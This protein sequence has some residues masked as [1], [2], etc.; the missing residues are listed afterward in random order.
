MARDVLALRAGSLILA[1]IVAGCASPS[2]SPVRS[3]GAGEIT[4]PTFSQDLCA[5]GGFIQELRLRGD[6]AD[7][8]VVWLEN[9]AGE[10]TD[11]AW[12]PGS[13]ARFAPDLEILDPAGQVIAR[14]GA[15]ATGGCGTGAADV[16][17]VDFTTPAP[18]VT[19]PPMTAEP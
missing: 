5:G 12:L 2:P 6:S 18:D 4:V 19:E 14:E 3:L 17:Y 15:I 16:W 11:V 13:S 8:R 7:P 10:R 9:A 1:L